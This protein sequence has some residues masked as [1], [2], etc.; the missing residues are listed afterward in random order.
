MRER[1]T[2]THTHTHTH[3]HLRVLRFL[4]LG[5]GTWSSTMP[6]RRKKKKEKAPRL[7]KR[8]RTYFLCNAS[9]KTKVCIRMKA[10]KREAKKNT[11][12]GHLIRLM[13]TK[14]KKRR[15][16]GKKIYMA[17]LIYRSTS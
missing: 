14:A 12:C 10:T 11:I 2:Q 3:T 9:A 13:S 8:K 5:G 1:A 6:V 15:G 16:G 4:F 17:S 7:C